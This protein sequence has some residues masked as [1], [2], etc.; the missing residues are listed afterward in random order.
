MTTITWQEI[1]YKVDN[2]HKSHILHE[3]NKYS[4]VV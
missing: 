3:K 4:V 2:V 1:N